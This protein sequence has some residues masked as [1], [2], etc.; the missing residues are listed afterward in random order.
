MNEKLDEIFKG[1][2]FKR[3]YDLDKIYEKVNEVDSSLTKDDVKEY[4]DSKVDSYDFFKTPNNKYEPISKTSFRVGV[5]NGKGVV[6]CGAYNYNIDEKNING[7]IGSDLVLID[8]SGGIN[9]I[10]KVISRDLKYVMGEVY[11]DGSS[12]Y[13]KPI[14]EDKQNLTI[15]VPGDE[16]IEGM[17]VYAY[18][19][20][21]IGDNYYDAHIVKKYGFK[22][23][24]GRDI[25]DEAYKY[26]VVDY[27]DDAIEKE[28]ELI[29]KKVLPADFIGRS[30]L[31]DKEIF[32][33]DGVDT[34][35]MDDAVS[36]ETLENGN[37]LL[38]V[39][40]ADVPNYVKEGSAIDKRAFELGFSYYLANKVIPMLP[41][42]LS[43]GICSLNPDVDR[44][45]ITVFA[46]IDRHGNIKGHN[47]EL[48]VI[49]SRLKMDY[50][51]V[52][53]ILDD[54]E[55]DSKYIP[56]VRTLKN[57][58]LLSLILKKKRMKEGA[59]DFER[60]E[61]KLITDEDGSVSGLSRRIQRKAENMIEEFMLVANTVVATEFYYN[62]LPFIYRNHGNPDPEKI[63]DFIY[64]INHLGYKAN[65]DSDTPNVCQKLAILLNKSHNELSDMLK[66]SLIK[67]QKRAEYSAENK[68]HFG[69]ALP[70]YTH[71]TSPIRRYPDLTVHR[72]IHK[73]I[74]E[75]DFDKKDLKSISKKLPV[76]AE[77]STQR[78]KAEDNCEKEV[79]RMKCAEY[80]E[81]H[82]GENFIGTVVSLDSNGMDVELDNMITGRVRRK[83]LDYDYELN[84]ATFS[85]MSLN[86][87]DDYYLGDVL[88]LECIRASKEDRIIDFKVL[89][90]YKENNNINKNEI[91][92]EKIL[93][94]D[95]KSKILYY[96]VNKGRK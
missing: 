19:D 63:N 36:L 28:L 86:G 85:Y 53:N 27:M 78:D 12:Y 42:E 80:M 7:A 33:I 62:K 68:G 21:M 77:Q 24:P 94:K 26:G 2:K 30:D 76:I 90:K 60:D 65:M 95:E 29:P 58:Y 56:F 47:I 16:H 55:F 48:G 14:D 8:T 96:N 22:D 64:M 74:I 83:D 89:S 43:N 54:K 72:L 79:M 18:L 82:I 61:L 13:I 32:T 71:F 46:E 40:I 51:N 75:K 41:H 57:M 67:C 15:R 88:N 3:A 10:R 6:K 84:D 23:D 59:I 39:H 91:N 17:R 20:N 4:L 38:G 73:F 92:R 87:F 9:R 49:K 31:R 81:N 66:L 1:I 50:D 25:L 35:D 69:L 44:L 37:F 5:Y 52:N 93:K 45:T 11:K 70:C 34:K